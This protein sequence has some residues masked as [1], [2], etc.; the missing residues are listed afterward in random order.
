MKVLV[1]MS[2]GVDS[3]V[4]ALQMV[5]EGHEVLGVFLRLWD[6][7]AGD[8]SRCCSLEDLADAHAVA[9]QLGIELHEECSARD[10]LETVLVP[11]L[12]IY[13]QGETP[14]PC[15]VCN[16]HV[17]FSELERVADEVRADS[18][19]T[20]HYARIINH[21]DGRTTLHRGRDRAKDQSYYLHRLTRSRLQRIRFPLGGFTK[22]DARRLAVE[23]ELPV[24]N[25]DESQELCFVPEGTTY[26]SLIDEW[27]PDRETKGIIVDSAGK[28]LGKHS[29]VQ[30]YTVGQRRGLG[31]S[32]PEPL[33]VL[34]L[35]AD[36][37][38][39]VVGSREELDVAWFDVRDT[40]W[41]SELVPDGK[42]VCSAQIRS[43]HDGVEA[44]VEA[45]PNSGWVRVFPREPISAPAPGQAAVFYCGDEVLGGGW[46]ARREDARNQLS[47]IR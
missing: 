24:A 33:Y 21:D 18:I 32:A 36:N 1:A 25:K 17:K 31:I 11:S 3:S 16:Q 6:S 40:R 46:I 22:D 26:A 20:G 27:L 4:A 38:T 19:V 15:V 7:S 28:E 41:I 37:R 39:V 30:H 12:E 44:V 35:D 45:L 2:G 8:A 13:A 23:A 47:D 10:F 43:R 34:S 42:I 9:K 14:N 5:R 29:G